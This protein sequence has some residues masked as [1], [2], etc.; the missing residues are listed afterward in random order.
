M[1]TIGLE[2]PED[3]IEHINL[4]IFFSPLGVGER[5][6]TRAAIYRSLRA[7]GPE[8]AKKVS[9]RVFLFT[10]KDSKRSGEKSQKNT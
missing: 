3:D 1:Q 6:A 5:V 4:I 10:K 8:I 9:K 2:V 7:S